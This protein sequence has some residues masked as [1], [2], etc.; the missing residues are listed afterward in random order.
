MTTASPTARSAAEALNRSARR[1]L[2]AARQG[3][4]N[5]AVIDAAADFSASAALFT[6]QG[7]GTQLRLERVSGESQPPSLTV[8]IETA[9]ALRDVVES[10]EPVAAAW[11]SGEL[12]GPLTETLTPLGF[13]R[14]AH[15][16]P[17]EGAAHRVVAVLLAT[18]EREDLDINALELVCTL[19]GAAWRLHS[20]PPAG[21]DGARAASIQLVNLAGAQ[22]APAPNHE[23][24]QRARRYAAVKVAEWRLYEAAKVMRGRS[25]SN[26]Y[27][28]FQ[29]EIDR[30]RARFRAV[31]LEK[32][33]TMV[34]YLHKEMIRTLTQGRAAQMGENYPG[35]M[36]RS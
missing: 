11:T 7:G 16:F 24:H 22:P 20:T 2:P 13:A 14:R 15:L 9:R 3:D 26:L 23:L 18:G 4:W 29:E 21:N 19:A 36:E 35:A 34:D 10:R 28:L 17:V 12:S 27:E 25:E 1:I 32:D 8:G 33:P 31:F 30:E 6:V 5:S